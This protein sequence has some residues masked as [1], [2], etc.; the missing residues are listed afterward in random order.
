MP[1]G[2]LVKEYR[3]TVTVDAVEIEVRHIEIE[4]FEGSEHSVYFREPKSTPNSAT[5]YYGSEMEDESEAAVRARVEK[6][7]QWGRDTNM[8]VPLHYVHV[9]SVDSEGAARHAFGRFWPG[10]EGKDMLYSIR[11]SYF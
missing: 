6:A 5:S 2:R 11:E 1:H 4:I 9:R 8:R 3:E 10:L 7:F